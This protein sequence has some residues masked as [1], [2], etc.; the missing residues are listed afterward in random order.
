M[1]KEIIQF[2][3]ELS[4]NNNR[5]WFQA[6]KDRFDVLHK[7][8]ID[9]VQEVINRIALFDPQVAGLAS[10]DCQFRIYR[11][12][13]FRRTRHLIRFILQLIWPRAD[14]PASG[15][16]IISISNRVPVCCPVAYGVLRLNY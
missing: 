2:L 4:V 5:E 15:A 1:N 11:D 6:N 8:F 16:D 13:R 10:K 3:K 7:G 14:V 9:E 12:L